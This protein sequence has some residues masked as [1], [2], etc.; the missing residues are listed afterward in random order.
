MRNFF[1]NSWLF[2]GPRS[3]KLPNRF[4]YVP[5]FHLHTKIFYFVMGEKEGKKKAK[6]KGTC[7]SLWYSSRQ[8]SWKHEDL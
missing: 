1:L 7:L 6:K 5:Y 3:F 2:V 8:V 4:K